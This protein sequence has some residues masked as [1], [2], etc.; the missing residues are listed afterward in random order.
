MYDELD[1]AIGI[2]EWEEIEGFADLAGEGG[3]RMEG[4]ICET[5]RLGAKAGRGRTD[6]ARASL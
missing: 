2:L 1:R 5:R 4:D 6:Q 3:F